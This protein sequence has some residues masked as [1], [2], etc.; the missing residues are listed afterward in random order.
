MKIYQFV[1]IN[2]NILIMHNYYACEEK[3]YLTNY[4]AATGITYHIYNLYI[5]LI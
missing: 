1:L 5:M 4:I 3:I 2:Y